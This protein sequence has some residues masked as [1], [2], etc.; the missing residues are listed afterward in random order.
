MGS[1]WLFL[2][3]YLCSGF[4]GLIY[5]VSWTRLATLYLGHTTAAASTVVAA[6]MGGLAGGAAIGGAIANRIR[7]AQALLTYV[8]LECVVIVLALA[9]PWELKALTPLLR[10]SYANG[11]PGVLF[12]SIRLLSCLILFTVPS[13]AIGATF[14]MAI[15]WF[16]TRPQAL[17]GSRA[18]STPRTRSARPPVLSRPA[19][20][21]CQRSGCS[22][23]RS[24]GFRRA[25]WP[26]DRRL[27]VVG[28]TS[29]GRPSGCLD[30]TA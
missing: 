15:R 28:S 20:F 9:L 25:R 1:A 18:A 5:E 21:C 3:A 17:D 7:P 26:P 29:L 2:A 13:L 11:N 19:S 4:A 6:F 16:V 12:A 23:P 8:V 30:R 22:R 14:P 10:S 24:S 27:D